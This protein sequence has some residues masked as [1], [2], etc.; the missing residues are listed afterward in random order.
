[1]STRL[2]HQAMDRRRHDR[3]PIKIP[4]DYSAVDAF[5]TE[6]ATNM[7]EGGMFVETASP[8]G[9]GS[10]VQ[11]QFRLP[12]LDE[13]VHVDGRVAWVS[14]GKTDGPAGMGIE[15]QNLSRQARET[16]NA[17]VRRLRSPAP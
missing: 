1:M 3:A 14:D 11:L 17:L 15:F 7:N 13:P 16:I 8:A 12:G 6:F 4:V 9:I 5:F 10:F 2:Q